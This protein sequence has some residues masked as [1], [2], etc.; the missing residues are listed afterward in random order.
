VTSYA[1]HQLVR[2]KS[3]NFMRL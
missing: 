3:R 1:S 2:V